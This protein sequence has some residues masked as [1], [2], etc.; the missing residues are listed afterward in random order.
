MPTSHMPTSH[1]KA[2]TKWLLHTQQRLRD[3]TTSTHESPKNENAL[4]RKRV[5]GTKPQRNKARRIMPRRIQKVEKKL[6]RNHT[7]ARKDNNKRGCFLN[8]GVTAQATKSGQV[9]RWRL[10]SRHQARTCPRTQ[11]RKTPRKR[12]LNRVEPVTGQKRLDQNEDKFRTKWSH[13]T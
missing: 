2:T 12:R 6:L 8:N 3:K 1:E 7:Q 11:H 9:Q 13:T 10:M 5:L 4:D